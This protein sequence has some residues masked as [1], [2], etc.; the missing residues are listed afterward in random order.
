MDAFDIANMRASLDLATL[1]PAAD[2]NPRV[3]CVIATASGHVAGG[4]YHRGSGTPH[5][6]VAALADAAVNGHDVTGGTAYVTLEPCAHTGRTGPCSQAL[7]DAGVR[8]VVVLR[9]D[10]G[11]ESS[12]GAEKLR[13]A[14]VTVDVL[15]D[16]LD[17][18]D[19][20]RHSGTTPDGAETP[21]ATATGI[22]PTAA[23]TPTAP[24]SRLDG[25]PENVV[26]PGDREVLVAIAQAAADLVEPWE[27]A[28]RNG[29]P[30]V[31][32]KYAST[33]DGRSA[34]RDGSSRWI[35]GEAA[36]ADVHVRRAAAGA[37]V[38]GTGTV[39]ADDPALTV[40]DE[41]GQ[42]VGRQPLR[43][44]VGESEVPPTAKVFAAVEQAAPALH[45]RTRDVATVLAEL[46]ERRIRHVWLEGGPT[47]AAAFVA[48]GAVDEIVAYLAPALLGAGTAAV[49]DLGIDDMGD[50]ARFALSSVER[51]GDDVRIVLRPTPANPTDAPRTPHPERQDS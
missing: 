44:I 20:S 19:G 3:G 7:I 17:P 32:W 28:T 37:V 30:F 46:H 5:A 31:T 15:P 34:A 26:G 8:R 12:G 14:G 25:A 11:D 21:T 10:P 47:L 33:L 22:A 1:G 9:R 40:R 13:T 18:L 36:R 50:I 42:P 51:V 45:L 39:L 16:L 23:P 43:V 2:P 49:G 48:A 6:E 4:G 29:R 41:T 38:A 24:T 27:F 35:T